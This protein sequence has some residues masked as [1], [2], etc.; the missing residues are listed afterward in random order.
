MQQGDGIGDVSLCV[1]EVSEVEQE[2]AEGVGSG[3]LHEGGEV[4]GDGVDM[5]VGADINAIVRRGDY[6]RR[7]SHA[8][9]VCHRLLKARTD[10]GAGAIKHPRHVVVGIAGGKENYECDIK[11]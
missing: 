6:H 1:D 2:R 8:V 11:N 10:L 3:C 5:R 4:G 9:V 7:D